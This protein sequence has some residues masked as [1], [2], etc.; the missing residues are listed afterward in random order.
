MRIWVFGKVY[1]MDSMPIA[2]I[3]KDMEK[4]LN[5]YIPYNIG[6]K[7]TLLY[8]NEI[9][10]VYHRGLNVEVSNDEII[11]QDSWLISGE[12]YKGFVP[13]YSTTSGFGHIISAY[14]YI[15]KTDFYDA[16]M[17]NAAYYGADKVKHV[18]IDEYPNMLVLKIQC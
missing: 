7:I 12:G 6:V 2:D 15:D 14:Y 1:N 13:A 9:E 16:Y 3:E 4:R 17:K 10:I 8:D 18:E 11:E 5:D